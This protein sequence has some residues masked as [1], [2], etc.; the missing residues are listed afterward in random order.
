[1]NARKEIE[2]EI[3]EQ[4]NEQTRCHELIRVDRQSGTRTLL[5]TCSMG[6]DVQ[7]LQWWREMTRATW[8]VES[9]LAMSG[10]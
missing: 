2:V 9:S 7:I 4:S 3:I 10:P 6:V 8:R 5:S 1:M